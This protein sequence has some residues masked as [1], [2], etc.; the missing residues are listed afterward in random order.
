MSLPETVLRS[1]NLCGFA[2]ACFL[3]FIFCPALAAHLKLEKIE[4]KRN[5]GGDNTQR[6]RTSIEFYIND[7][8]E[9]GFF[10][11]DKSSLSMMTDDLGRDLIAEHRAIV[12]K[13]REK[14]KEEA[15][16]IRVDDNGSFSFS[17]GP[18]YFAAQ[19]PGLSQVL[20]VQKPS[21]FLDPRVGLN[22]RIVTRAIP[23]IGATRVKLAGRLAYA[24]TGEMSEEK[25][26]GPVPLKDGVKFELPDG[27]LEITQVIA[28]RK[29]ATFYLKGS[30]ALKSVTVQDES[31]KTVAKM[32]GTLNGMPSVQ[33]ELDAFGGEERLGETRYTITINYLETEEHMIEFDE[34]IELVDN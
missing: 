1:I 30:A 32:I 12:E 29:S 28:M 10:Y 23:S 17:L 31:G 19:D 16:S 6:N 13:I 2:I 25:I 4:I 5:Q 18:A 9:F 8:K 15:E 11:E 3:S 27:T 7:G 21:I 20:S 24:T 22:L 34:V 33:G 14:A 26:F